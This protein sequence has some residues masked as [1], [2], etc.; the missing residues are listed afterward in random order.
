[1]NMTKKLYW[2][3][4]LLFSITTYSQSLTLQD[5]TNEISCVR[6]YFTL[7][8]S[9]Q[10]SSIVFTNKLAYSSV[11]IGLIAG[12][13]GAGVTL[14]VL[15][16]S[17]ANSSN[18]DMGC[19]IALTFGPIIVGG[20]SFLAGTT[21]G[22]VINS[23]EEKSMPN[24]PFSK[25]PLLSIGVL[26]SLSYGISKNASFEEY[27]FGLSYRS[28]CDNPFIPNRL[29][30]LYKSTLPTGYYY[31]KEDS[32]F[33]ESMPK[34]FI[35]KKIGI[36]AV[37]IGHNNI[38]GVIYGVEIGYTNVKYS[39]IISRNNWTEQSNRSLPYLDIIAGLNINLFSFLS[40][41]IVYSYEIFGSYR[42]LK[43]S[44]GELL[45]NSQ[46]V[47]LNMQIYFK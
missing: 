29:S 42:G 22:Y 5:T 44:N 39:S 8:D 16:I 47:G 24:H 30:L 15:A 40:T 2:V 12:A 43:E 19:A 9:I 41:E 46:T 1:M 36:N 4:L 28:L 25:K 26:S 37:H 20:I 45:S 34:E 14:G 32:Y 18:C 38:F 3:I 33:D 31:Y 13:V 21:V 10:T 27:V 11:K 7:N 17:E 35:E 23:S 6:N